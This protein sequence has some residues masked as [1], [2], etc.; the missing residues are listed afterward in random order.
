MDS[1][2]TQ[3]ANVIDAKVSKTYNDGSEKSFG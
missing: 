3:T 1:A 2:I